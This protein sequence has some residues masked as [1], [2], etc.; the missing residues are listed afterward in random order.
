MYLFAYYWCYIICFPDKGS[1]KI[2]IR[3]RLKHMRRPA[4]RE[5]GDKENLPVE[6]PSKRRKTAPSRLDETT[7]PL[8]PEDE[9]RF[10]DDVKEMEQ[11]TARKKRKLAHLKPLMDSTFS[12][13]RHWI[14]TE[15]PPVDT[16]IKKFPALKI[17]RLVSIELILP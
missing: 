5:I 1:W 10:R 12:G 16:I 15:M 8:E 3:D 13:R 6:K 2:K 14:K 4:K 11:Q 17:P 7:E 9:Q